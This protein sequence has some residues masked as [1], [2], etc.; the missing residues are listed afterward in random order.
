MT[1]IHILTYYSILVLFYAKM[2][3]YDDVVELNPNMLAFMTSLDF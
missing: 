3:H 1:V 2:N